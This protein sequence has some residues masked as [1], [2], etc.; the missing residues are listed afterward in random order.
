MSRV[1]LE[2]DNLHIILEIVSFP[3]AASFEKKDD[4]CKEGQIDLLER[5]PF[6]C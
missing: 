4:W 3:I 6:A 1:D 2:R 5:V